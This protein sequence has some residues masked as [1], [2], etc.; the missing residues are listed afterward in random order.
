MIEIIK[1]I[2]I[3]CQI[4][5]GGSAVVPVERAQISCQKYYINCVSKEK[6]SDTNKLE[7]CIL[8]RNPR[9]EVRR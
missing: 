1:A 7:Q 3:L 5:A 9:Q 2:A 6:G 8:K 4:N